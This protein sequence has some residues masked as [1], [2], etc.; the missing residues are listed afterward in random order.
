VST[1]P[2]TET[3]NYN[4]P[5]PELATKAPTKVQP[6]EEPIVIV[7][8]KSNSDVCSLDISTQPEIDENAQAP[9]VDQNLIKNLWPFIRPTV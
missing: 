2:D 3:S 7:A 5:H 6:K 9:Q 8:N 1:R 4:S